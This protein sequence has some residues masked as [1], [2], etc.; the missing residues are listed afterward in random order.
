MYIIYIFFNVYQP[1][2]T[3]AHLG[4][5]CQGG[6]DSSVT[7]SRSGRPS[8]R[9]F[10]VAS[11]CTLRHGG[12]EVEDNLSRDAGRQLVHLTARDNGAQCLAPACTAASKAAV[13][14]IP[15]I[16][17]SLYF[18]T[19]KNSSICR[20]RAARGLECSFGVVDRLLRTL[21]TIPHKTQESAAGLAQ[22]QSAPD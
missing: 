1:G 21:Q 15:S 10:P 5:R 20:G 9:T 4:A 17:R 8:W 18:R 13:S 2:P 19:L 11:I 12:K 14:T 6:A 3:A 22:R 16:A 7:R